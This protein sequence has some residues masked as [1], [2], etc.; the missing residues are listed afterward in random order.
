M[1]EKLRVMISSRCNDK[2]LCKDNEE[3]LF[4][5]LRRYLKEELEKEEMLGFE[6]LEVFIS[7]DMNENV[8]GDALD[9][10]LQEII[11]ADIILVLY[12]G[13]AGW[14]VADT[15]GI[16]VCQAEF[17]EA[18]NNNPAKTCLI[19]FLRTENKDSLKFFFDSHLNE[20]GH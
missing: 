4:T 3:L 16:G 17:E 2:I 1:E 9:K 11:A 5:D 15:G 10:S 7:E 8:E 6:Y 12:N 19:D 20:C 14:V 13:N 18:Y